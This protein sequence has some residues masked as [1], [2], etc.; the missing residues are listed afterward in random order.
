MTCPACKEAELELRPGS[1]RDENTG[2]VDEDYAFCVACGDS[3]D[4]EDLD[5]ESELEEKAA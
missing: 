2:Y 4:F 5:R 3:F 1:G